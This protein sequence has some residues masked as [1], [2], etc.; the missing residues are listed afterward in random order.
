MLKSEYHAKLEG[1]GLLPHMGVLPHPTLSYYV[2]FC[3]FVISRNSETIL[4]PPPM[5]WLTVARP[6]AFTS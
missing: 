6:Y 5:F 4:S 2:A 1:V 3:A